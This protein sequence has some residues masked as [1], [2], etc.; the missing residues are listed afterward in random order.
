MLRDYAALEPVNVWGTRELLRL[1]AEG[2]PKRLHYAS[3]LSVFVA[4][5][6]N[7]G[8]VFEDDDL[9]DHHEVFGG[10]AQT[11][12][13]AEW[14]VRGTGPKLGSGTIHRFGLLVEADDRN[15]APLA[16]HFSLFIQGL[17]ELGSY[18]EQSG[19]DDEPEVDLTPVDYAAAAMVRLSL[20]DRSEGF[21]T[22][23]LANPR[24]TRL[25]ELTTAIRAC[26][27]PLR[28]LP[29][30]DWLDRIGAAS[31]RSAAAAL[32]LSRCFSG[33]SGSAA[34]RTV[35]LFQAT[36]VTFDMTRAVGDLQGTG[37]SCPVPEP[38]LV[39]RCVRA[40]LRRNTAKE[41]QW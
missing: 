17:A 21:C 41:R 27:V 14:M 25:G 4:S 8:R 24:S 13:A 29:V 18:P 37:L 34:H 32:A 6:R 19:G 35:D 2:R 16:D 9:R 31:P 5:D 1:L 23:H 15:P 39:E 7:R 3:T 33:L 12:W 22:Y 20:Q 11:K 26:G 28:A 36:G 30:G 38:E 10:Y 40:A